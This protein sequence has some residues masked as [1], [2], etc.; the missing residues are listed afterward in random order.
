VATL[1]IH[2]QIRG[3]SRAF[4]GHRHAP[5]VHALGPLDLD[6]IR[7]E[8]FSVVGPSGCGKSTL[9]DAMAGLSKIV[10]GTVLFEGQY[11][12]GNVPDGIGVVFQE[13]SSLLSGCGGPALMLRKSSGGSSM[14]LGLSA[15][16][17]LSA[18]TPH[19]CRVECGNACA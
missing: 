19:S 5:A 2:V 18:P 14:R 17:I 7:G 9:L 13:D 10:E 4:G 6:L 16:A 11:V 12:N 1:D 3:L 8:F 15:C